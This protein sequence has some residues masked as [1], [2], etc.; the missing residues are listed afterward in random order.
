MKEDLLAQ[1]AAH[2]QTVLAGGKT[3]VVTQLNLIL[4]YAMLLKGIAGG[5]TDGKNWSVL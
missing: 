4:K 5:L 1:C 3:V 2:I